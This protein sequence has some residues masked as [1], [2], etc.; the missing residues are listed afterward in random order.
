[1]QSI[2][3]SI[4][5][6]MRKQGTHWGN[7]GIPQEI[8]AKGSVFQTTVCTQFDWKWLSFPLA[9]LTLTTLLLSVVCSKM[10]FDRQKIPA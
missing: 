3:T 6:E 7:R 5:S 1:M 10:L 9:L 2:A 4:A 8:F